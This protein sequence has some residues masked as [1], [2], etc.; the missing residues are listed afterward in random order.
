M[1]KLRT[2]RAPEAA[3]IAALMKVHENLSQWAV[4]FM[5]ADGSVYAGV[6]KTVSSKDEQLTITFA[7]IDVVHETRFGSAPDISYPQPI[8]LLRK[9][10]HSVTFVPT[11]H[12][13]IRESL[14]AKEGETVQA[15]ETMT[16]TSDRN[17]KY[18]LTDRRSDVER[19]GL[20]FQANNPSPEQKVA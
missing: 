19:V 13:H 7:W 11:K 15:V 20:L 4:E 10:N 3:K 2:L 1:K 6:P 14:P 18:V 17:E 5:V 12:N 9:M 16:I 8:H